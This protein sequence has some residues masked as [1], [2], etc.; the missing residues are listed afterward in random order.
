MKNRTQ[1]NNN[2]K[3]LENLNSM[4]ISSSS[5]DIHTYI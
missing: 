1:N 5:G 4:E 2:K 3:K